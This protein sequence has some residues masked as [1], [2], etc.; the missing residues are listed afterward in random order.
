MKL[1][2]LNISITVL[3]ASIFVIQS[4]KKEDKP[5]K[6][7]EYV[8]SVK[9]GNGVTDID[10][11][12]YPSTIIGSQEWMAA[13]LKTTRYANGDSLRYV[14]LE[15]DWKQLIL[16]APLF[17]DGAWCYYE[18]DSSNNANYGKLYNFHAAIDERGLCPEG[19]RVPS[20][21]DWHQLAKYI[22]PSSI[23]DSIAFN[24]L[25]PNIKIRRD[26]IESKIAGGH[27]K[28]LLLWQDPNKGADNKTLFNAL[29][30]GA[31][32][33]YRSDYEEPI[34]K[35]REIYKAA[36]FWT[37]TKAME[38]PPEPEAHFRLL[39]FDLPYLEQRK[40]SFRNGLSVR[41]LKE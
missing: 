25:Q 11:N 9:E 17:D 5:S 6:E 7:S 10:G 37:T 40:S 31:R 27:L 8:I 26:G 12:T 2:V 4:C 30:A 18:N 21:D 36:A 24:P 41:C 34:Y 15:E 16:G 33:L 3:I 29:P 39:S 32:F 20:D 22:D 13:N 23:I 1:T 35:F 28:S 14:E 19:W 38:F